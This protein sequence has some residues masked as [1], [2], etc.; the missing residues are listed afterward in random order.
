MISP[1]FFSKNG[2]PKF[3]DYAITG[4][5]VFNQFSKEPATIL[6][7]ANRLSLPIEEVSA[8]LAFYEGQHQA[9]FIGS[10]LCDESGK[11]SAY[12]STDIVLIRAYNKFIGNKGGAI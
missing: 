1:S 2:K 12:F 7:A 10:D 3:T 4:Q 11:E 8:Y 6:M 5:Q 9:Q